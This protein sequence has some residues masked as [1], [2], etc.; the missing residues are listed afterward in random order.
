MKL[1][2]NDIETGNAVSDLPANIESSADV[3]EFTVF[4]SLYMK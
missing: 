2:V 1:A 3:S 4:R